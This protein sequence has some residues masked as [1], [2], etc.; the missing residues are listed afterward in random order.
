M[1][2]ILI[3]LVLSFLVFSCNK[4]EKSIELTKQAMNVFTAYNLDNTTR[5]DSSLTLLNLAIELDK[6]N[7]KAYENK[8]GLLSQKKRYRR[9]VQLRQ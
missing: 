8:Y 4:K 7:F 2:K 3:I 6:D 9:N 5:V 1:K